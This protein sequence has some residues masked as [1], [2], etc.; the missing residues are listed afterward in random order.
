M[1]GYTIVRVN[2]G[3]SPWVKYA[4]QRVKD[5]NSLNVGVFGETGSGKSWSTL[6]FMYEYALAT[7]R[8]TRPE[9]FH[10]YF[11]AYD[12]LSE[13]NKGDKSK[14]KPGDTIMIDEAGIDLSSADWQSKLNKVM[15]LI[16]QTI[17]H[18]RYII[19]LTAPS[20]KFIALAVRRLLTA[21]WIALGH[22][23]KTSRMKTSQIQYNVEMDKAYV[24][25]I[26]M[27]DKEGNMGLVND[28]ELA[29]PPKELTDH[30]ERLKT[31]CTTKLYAKMQKELEHAEKKQQEKYERKTGRALSARQA[32]VQKLL[33]Q[34]L[35]GQEIMRALG[36]SQPSVSIHKAKARSRLQAQARA[37][38]DNKKSG[39]EMDAS[40]PEFKM[41]TSNNER[42]G[43]GA[44]AQDL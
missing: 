32:Q 1:G 15:S 18:R 33:D 30:Y 44:G 24:K 23:D 11:D 27:M 35:K 2:E 4:I 42:T 9:D 29:R 43:A 31:E 14:F 39:F 16:F 5:N 36:L 12:V 17:R 10:I 41:P 20:P 37:D 34:G 19:F 26:A 28:M 25:R 6:A 38:V 40:A 3:E 21:Q 13:I 22:D 8:S 7:G